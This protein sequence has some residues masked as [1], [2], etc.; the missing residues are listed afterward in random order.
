MEFASILSLDAIIPKMKSAS[1]KQVFQDLATYAAEKLD[2]PAEDVLA[3]L[4]ERE[5][6][7]NTGIGKGIALPH[8][9]LPDIAAI[10]GLFAKLDNPI[11]YDAADNQPVDLVF[12]LLAPEE[13][14]AEHLK[15]LASISRMLR[16]DPIC[17]ALRGA[18]T[19]EAMYVVLTGEH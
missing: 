6:L 18:E 5:K 2:Y 4:V 7:G 15:A 10:T 3:H 14:G 13:C 8:A 17:A 11:D 9:K 12:L 19:A 1:K 16:D